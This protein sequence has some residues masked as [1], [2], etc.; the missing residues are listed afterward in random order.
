V[1][2]CAPAGVS[3]WGIT[4]LAEAGVPLR[5]GGACSAWVG[6]PGS[7]TPWNVITPSPKGGSA[8][9]SGARHDPPGSRRSRLCAETVVAAASYLSPLRTIFRLALYCVPAHWLL[10]Q[11]EAVA[12][13]SAILLK[14]RRF[15]RSVGRRLALLAALWLV[16][17]AALALPV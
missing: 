9:P 14:A 13:Q 15:P 12:T 1:Q 4:F 16:R 17:G 6:R 5:L 10:T 8:V 7:T 11:H 3:P 2:H